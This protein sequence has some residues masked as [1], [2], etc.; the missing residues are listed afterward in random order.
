LRRDRIEHLAAAGEAEIVD[1]AQD[2]TRER[3]AGLDVARAVEVR[4]VD[5]SL[6][7]DRRAGL[8]EVGAH[9][10]HEAIAVRLGERR[11]PARVLEGGVGVVDRA[12]S[13]HHEQTLA[14]AA[15]QDVADRAARLQ[16]HVGGSFGQRLRGLHGAR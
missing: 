2:P 15:V 16:H 10:D 13:D 9:D 7:S 5:E 14:V 4:V 6:P 11:E 3:E 1:L 8:L 12:G